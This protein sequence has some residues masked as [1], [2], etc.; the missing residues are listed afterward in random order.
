M[1][2]TYSVIIIATIGFDSGVYQMSFEFPAQQDWDT[3]EQ[4]IE[5]IENREDAFKLLHGLGYGE[6]YEGH[7]SLTDYCAT[8]MA[9]YTDDEPDVKV[10]RL[11]SLSLKEFNDEVHNHFEDDEEM[12]EVLHED[13]QQSFCRNCGAEGSPLEPDGAKGHCES[14]GQ[15]AVQSLAICMNII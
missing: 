10:K 14:C 5:D 9:E 13:V 8:L 3:I 1:K 2:S 15:N 6:R 4:G 12:Y 7:A 11:Y